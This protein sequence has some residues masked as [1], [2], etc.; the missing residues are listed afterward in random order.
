MSECFHDAVFVNGGGGVVGI[1]LEHVKS[2]THSHTDACILNHGSVV[3]SIT[4]SYC[5]LRI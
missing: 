3:A 5:I 1:L 4:K 2:I